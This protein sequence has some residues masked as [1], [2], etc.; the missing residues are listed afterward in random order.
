M[1]KYLS[2]VILLVIIVAV[3]LFSGCNGI[4]IGSGHLQTETI[5]YSDFTLVDVSNAFEVE[6][7][8]SES[9][10]VSLT[11]DDNLLE[12]IRVSKAG[13][14]LKV[15]VISSGCNFTNHMV[16]I[17]M[18]EIYGV[19]FSG[20]VHG[21][22]RDFSFA[23][24]FSVNISGASSLKMNNMSV[25]NIKAE[26][27]GASHLSGEILAYDAEFDISGASTINFQGAADDVIIDASGSSRVEFDNFMV[28]NV[29]I[30]LS[31]ASSS[32]INLSGRLDAAL[33]GASHL[34]YIGAPIMGDLNISDA[35]TLSK[36]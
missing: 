11:A 25:R 9:F 2:F 27:S 10:N 30:S 17:T 22:A 36:K 1:K 21:I 14:T 5:D 13:E 15:D 35:S 4:I 33:S 3:F 34:S 12:Y 23:Q 29:D 8:Q 24:D 18:P 7:I 6:I 19:K 20:A 26:I 28:E 31:G 32:V 16:R